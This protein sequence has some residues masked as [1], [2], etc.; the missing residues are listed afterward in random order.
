MRSLLLASLLLAVPA[1]AAE[2]TSGAAADGDRPFEAPSDRATLKQAVDR[3]LAHNPTIAIA[4]AELRRAA[5]LVEQVRSAALPSAILAG[6]YI[7]YDA[8][9]GFTYPTEI[10]TGTVLVNPNTFVGSL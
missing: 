6:Q 5:D 9:G 10:G 4:T 1:S 3:A 8:A 2:P 7:R